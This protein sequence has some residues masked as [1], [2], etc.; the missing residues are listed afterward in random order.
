MFF[1]PAVLVLLLVICCASSLGPN[2]AFY[3]KRSLSGVFH[4]DQRIRYSLTFTAAK[5]A[6]EQHFGAVMATR[7]QLY[8]AYLAGL[9]ECRAGWILSGEVVYP[10]IHRNWNCGQNRVGIIS[11]GVRKN[12]SEKWDVYCYKPGDDCSAYNKSL[13]SEDDTSDNKSVDLLLGSIMPSSWNNVSKK[14]EIAKAEL[15]QIQ[16]K[17]NH[18]P[19]VVIPSSYNKQTKDLHDSET[20]PSANVTL[21]ETS[22]ASSI[23]GSEKNNFKELMKPFLTESFI[24][25]SDSK[26]LPQVEQRDKIISASQL[27]ANWSKFEVMN[28]STNETEYYS[29]MTN[30]SIGTSSKINVVRLQL[31]KVTVDKP[32]NSKRDDDLGY[33]NFKTPQVSLRRKSSPDRRGVLSMNT[34]YQHE[35]TT[36]RHQPLKQT[37]FNKVTVTETDQ[38]SLD[39]SNEFQNNTQSELTNLLLLTHYN[40]S[41]FEGEQGGLSELTSTEFSQQALKHTS[42]VYEDQQESMEINRST[43]TPESA[44]YVITSEALQPNNHLVTERQKF[45]SQELPVTTVSVE[46]NDKLRRPVTNTF[47]TETFPL[48]TSTIA[49]GLPLEE[50]IIDT[51]DSHRQSISTHNG[52]SLNI[53]GESFSAYLEEKNEHIDA[54]NSTHSLVNVKKVVMKMGKNDKSNLPFQFQGNFKE[55]EV[56]LLDTVNTKGKKVLENVVRGS[57]VHQLAPTMHPSASQN[58]VPK[59]DSTALS[60]VST[61]DDNFH[62]ITLK[63]E[64]ISYPTEKTQNHQIDL[65][66]DETTFSRTKST[67]ETMMKHLQI[68]GIALPQN[69]DKK[70][71][72]V[73][74]S[75]DVTDFPGASSTST[76]VEPITFKTQDFSQAAVSS[77]D[78]PENVNVKSNL[79]VNNDKE[80]FRSRVNDGIKL[81]TP[82]THNSGSRAIVNAERNVHIDETSEINMFQPTAYSTDHTSEPL[83]TVDSSLLFRVST[84]L[85]QLQHSTDSE[86]MEFTT[87]IGERTLQPTTS[88]GNARISQKNLAYEK[89]SRN[90]GSL[91]QTVIRSPGDVPQSITSNAKDKTPVS[92]TNTK[93]YLHMTRKDGKVHSAIDKDTST[94]QVATTITDIFEPSL[95]LSEESVVQKNASENVQEAIAHTLTGVYGDQVVKGTEG[96][97]LPKEETGRYYASH[98]T[99]GETLP[100]FRRKSVASI[101]DIA[102]DVLSSATSSISPVTM[103]MPTVHS[104]LNLE[105]LSM[106]AF[107]V[108]TTEIPPRGDNVRSSTSS[109]LNPASL[110]SPGAYASCGGV[111]RQ[112]EGRFQTPHYPQSY[113]SDMDCTWEIE[114]PL[115]YL[116]RLDFT[117]LFIEEHRTC[118]YDY[119]VVYDGK[120]PNKVEMGRFCGSELPP[121]L[122]GSSNIMSITMRSDSSMELEGFS[123]QFSTFQVPEG[124]IHLDGRNNKYDGIIKIMSNGHWGGICAKHWTNKDAMVVCRQLGFSGPALA[125]R[126]DESRQNTSQTVPYINCKGDEMELQDCN[127]KRIGKCTSNEVAAVTCQVM[128]SCAALK[129][130]GILKSG[131]FTIDPDGVDGGVDPFPVECD[132]ASDPA[133]GITVIGHDSEDRI[134][135]SPCEDAGCYSRTIHYKQASL[136]QLKALT[137]SAKYCK[138]YVSLECRHIRFL[139]QHWGWWVSRDGRKINSWG[140]ASTDSGKCACGE[141]GNCA[142]GLST[143]NCDANDGVWRQDKGYLTDKAIL[144][145]REVRFGDTRDAPVEM[146]FYKIGPLHCFGQSSQVSVLESCAALKKAGF[147]ESRHYVIDPDG[148][149]RGVSPFEVFCDMTSDQATGSCSVPGMLCNCDINDHIWRTDEGM[150]D[151]KSSLPVRAVNF[152]DTNG[153]P[154]EMAFYTIGKLMCKGQA[155]R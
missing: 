143:C 44:K 109:F 15:T 126:V 139:K 50:A 146:A 117:S 12:L 152:G 90:K 78:P 60:G 5:L 92:V 49:P 151:D 135:V 105:D 97:P 22:T 85:D 18:F 110:K 88:S 103:Q 27:C 148:I 71:Q 1:N 63:V 47:N 123:A 113:P 129:N 70:M 101:T 81:R 99:D 17:T 36:I 153:A 128:E 100:S 64:G 87:S 65:T 68:Y 127:I 25:S 48:V 116:I 10:R 34:S 61:N 59:L 39:I 82:V 140:G 137:E 80:S 124:Y 96:A 79:F 42:S 37:L 86:R 76:H 77:I 4:Y 46:A 149:G 53:L 106:S 21:E 108:I 114:A 58:I 2:C 131:V 6:C 75:Q 8:A 51:N 35:I 74:S 7:E 26:Y 115:G 40:K 93:H 45:S 55:G 147:Q 38:E 33:N 67:Y 30:S 150:L 43:V 112:T 142:L 19:N 23:N 20:L 111:M 41:L 56:D 144:P 98:L 83:L 134:R 138:Q 125:T 31:Q 120:G 9:E 121:Q 95:G 54:I 66:G 62:P 69:V 13:H 91:L 84:S 28:N 141:N 73:T 155:G 52:N 154:L 132:M 133:T 57:S 11:Y 104:P 122:Q 107:P 94:L 14:Q 24:R 3:L 118:K 130:A 102:T 89:E 119:V 145:V 29:E 32:K 16:N 72:L 136:D